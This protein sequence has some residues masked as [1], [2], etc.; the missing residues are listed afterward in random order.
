MPCCGRAFC[1]RISTR[2]RFSH[3][4]E[5][6]NWS[7]AI[8]KSTSNA[9]SSRAVRLQYGALPYRFSAQG[10]LELLLVTSRT[11]GRWIIPKG[12]PIKGLKPQKSAAREA[13]EEA[14][15]RGAVTAK[16]IG[17]YSYDK[18]SDDE[19]GAI[20]CEILVFALNV[21]RQL[22]DWPEAREREARWVKPGDATALVEEDGL[23]SLVETFAE[24]AR[25]GTAARRT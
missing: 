2:A 8:A 12:W 11:R 17:R 14:G 16:P 13:F 21:K 6:P 7:R 22:K 9:K 4:T 10:E 23:R 1:S 20:P 19:S 15:V 25:H 18:I 3:P 24:R 5:Q